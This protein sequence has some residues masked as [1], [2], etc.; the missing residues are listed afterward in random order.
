VNVSVPGSTAGITTAEYE[1]GQ[2][3]DLKKLFQDLIPEDTYY[4]HDDTWGDANGYAHLRS[5]LIGTS[6]SF[7][8]IDAKLSLGTWQ[9]IVLIDFDNRPRLRKIILQFIGD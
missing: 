8:F 3:A 4:K 2:I 7:P 9:Q 1:P 6:K 5:A